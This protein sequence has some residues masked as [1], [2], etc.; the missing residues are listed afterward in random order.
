MDLP[1]DSVGSKTTFFRG[2]STDQSMWDRWLID[3]LVTK[4][5]HL[6]TEFTSDP[7]GALAVLDITYSANSRVS[8]PKN[9]ATP[10]ARDTPSISS[11]PFAV[12]QPTLS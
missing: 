10:V 9:S 5:Y 4:G 6:W 2:R 3:R 11:L 7:R 12:A 1:Q 8:P